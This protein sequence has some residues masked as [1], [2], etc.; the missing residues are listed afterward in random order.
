MARE[1]KIIKQ[2]GSNAVSGR[3]NDVKIST[4]QLWYPD[5]AK[6]QNAVNAAMRW[7]Y[8]RRKELYDLYD[9]AL[10]DA[11]LRGVIRKRK[12][13]VSQFPIEFRKDGEPVDEV[14]THIKSPWFRGFV[15]S[16]IDVKM[17]GFNAYQFVKDKDGWISVTNIDHRHVNPIT[18]ELLEYAN[19]LN[20]RPLDTFP[21]TLFLGEPNDIGDLMCVIPWVITKRQTTGD[22]A[23]YAQL[24]GMPI[25]EYTYDGTDSETLKEIKEEAECQGANGIYFHTSDTTMRLVDPATR[26]GSSEL[27][28]KLMAKCD[29]Q[30]SIHVLGNTLTTTVGDSGSRALGDVHKSEEEAI[31]EDDR[32]YVLDVLNYEMKD[33]FTAM[34]INTDGGEF[35][36]A[37]KKK[38]EKTQQAA[39]I[40]QMKG[41]GLPIDDE[42]IY[43]TLDIAKPE[44]YD[45]IKKEQEERAKALENALKGA[46]GSDKE[47]KVEEGNGEEGE[48]ATEGKETAKKEVN[49]SIV[50]R[51][52]NF[53]ADARMKRAGS[54][55]W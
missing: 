6:F 28:D 46:Q 22:W 5:V 8:P 26:S 47:D 14:N 16:L 36:Y 45:E 39:I 40:V 34:G 21:N 35:V 9:S 7:D 43:N 4:P 25:R 31:M 1:E 10:M 54:T 32:G 48:N 23:Q 20:G 44:N 17:W 11:H 15:K 51:V 55:A 12:I 13:A 19:D 30:I 27:Y 29:E 38:V 33:I 41:I 42:Y 49:D 3:N 24:F 2:G 53:F 52:L 18:K 37:E 50:E